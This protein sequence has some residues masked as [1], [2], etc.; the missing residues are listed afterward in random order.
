MSAAASELNRRSFLKL[1]AAGATGLVIGFYLPG[2]YEKLSAA[3]GQRADLNAWIHIS[4]DDRVTIFID[5]SEMGQSILTG[6]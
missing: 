6:L 1:G 3:T 2:R 5:K 4:P